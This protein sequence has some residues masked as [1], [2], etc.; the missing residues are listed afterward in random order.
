MVQDHTTANQQLMTIL[1][2]TDMTAPTQLDEKHRKAF[3]KLSKMRGAE[4]DRAYMR[5]MVED[6]DKTVKKFRQQATQG[7]NPDLK[8][9]AQDTLPVLEQHEKMAQDI[10]KSLAAVGSTR[11]PQGQRN[12]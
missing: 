7:S 10:S 9:F 5:E 2:A 11:E 6:H 12:R 3:E 1:A 8:E 4:F